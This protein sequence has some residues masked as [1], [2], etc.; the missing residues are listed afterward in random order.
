MTVNVLAVNSFTSLYHSQI[1][2]TFTVLHKTSLISECVSSKLL[3]FS[4]S[5]PDNY[6]FHC[7]AQNISNQSYINQN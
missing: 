5:F 4:L 2:I 1:I 6:H 3:H 7:A